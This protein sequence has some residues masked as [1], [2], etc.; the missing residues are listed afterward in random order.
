MGGGCY[1]E[2][3]WNYIV[4]FEMCLI[5]CDGGGVGDKASMSGEM[6]RYS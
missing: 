4:V 6:G 3:I 2:E 1:R 5:G